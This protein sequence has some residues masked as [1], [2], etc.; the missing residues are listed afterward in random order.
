MTLIN[1]DF[2]FGKNKI[3]GLF[4]SNTP[5]FFLR[6]PELVNEI[7]TNLNKY[8]MKYP[9]LSEIGDRFFEF[10]IQNTAT[11]DNWKKKRHIQSSGLYKQ[12]VIA[13][14]N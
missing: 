2:E 12:K 1:S 13:M 9:Y 4:H 7:Y 10:G 8:V 14:G 6:D 5:I 3:V 11:D